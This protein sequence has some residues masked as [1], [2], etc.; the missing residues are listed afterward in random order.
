MRRSRVPR[1]RCRRGR[2]SPPPVEASAR[3]DRA[4]K[5]GY[6]R[7]GAQHLDRLTRVDLAIAVEVT[8]SSNT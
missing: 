3:V 6:P 4:S 2:A 7:L 5:V 1:C 8:V